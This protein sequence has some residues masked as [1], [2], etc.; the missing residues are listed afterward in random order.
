MTVRAHHCRALMHQCG[1]DPKLFRDRKLA[2]SDIVKEI[3]KPICFL[4]FYITIHL[5]GIHEERLT[6][7]DAHTRFDTVSDVHRLRG[8]TTSLETRKYDF[9]AAMRSLSQKHVARKQAVCATVQT[10]GAHAAS[11]RSTGKLD[12]VSGAR[13]YFCA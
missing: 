8:G 3:V 6:E 11:S 4:L 9:A 2:A 5:P 12:L 10:N 13:A 7:S 1:R